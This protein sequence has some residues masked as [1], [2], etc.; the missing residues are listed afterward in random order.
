[1]PLDHLAVALIPNLHL[2]GILSF[3]WHTLA[4]LVLLLVR[5]LLRLVTALDQFEQIQGLVVVKLSNLV[6]ISVSMALISA[7]VS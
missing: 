3:H 1:M 4:H 2:F 7:V 5:V 6:Q